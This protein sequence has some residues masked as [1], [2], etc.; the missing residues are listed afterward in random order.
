MKL[1][2]SVN[3]N[4]LNSD[5]LPKIMKGSQKLYIPLYVSTLHCLKPKSQLPGHGRPRLLVPGAHAARRKGP[6]A[7]E[8]SDP[9][10][11]SCRASVS[12]IASWR[13]SATKPDTRQGKAP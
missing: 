7:S 12:G 3:E 2:L 11:V 8:H 9:R 1:F 4:D 6:A 13:A 10:W 5:I